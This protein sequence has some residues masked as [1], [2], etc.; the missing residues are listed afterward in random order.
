MIENNSVHLYNVIHKI[1]KNMMKKAFIASILFAI[2]TPFHAHNMNSCVD[3]LTFC[4]MYCEMNDGRYGTIGI[5][6]TDNVKEIDGRNYTEV[7]VGSL[8][9]DGSIR[10]YMREAKDQIMY[11]METLLKEGIFKYYREEEGKVYAYS[12]EK[13]EEELV[14]DFSLNVGDAFVRANGE[15]MKVMEVTDTMLFVYTQWERCK[16]LVL[17]SEDVSTEKDIW[18]EG[19]GSLNTGILSCDVLKDVRVAKLIG[20][21]ASTDGMYGLI[22]DIKLCPFAEDNFKTSWLTFLESDESQFPKVNYEFADDTLHLYGYM[23]Q[24]CV[25]SVPLQCMVKGNMIEIYEI[26]FP[27]TLGTTCTSIYKVDA[28]FSG[29]KNGVYQVSYNGGESVEVECGDGNTADASRVQD[30]DRQTNSICL[31][32]L[33]GRPVSTPIRGICVRNGKKIQMNQ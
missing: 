4:H 6:G 9:E 16:K 31:Y 13:K 32:D 10:L 21:S 26:H 11:S 12:E 23:E 15:K 3:G 8:K 7:N 20:R 5:V 28:K 1:Q 18:V 27:G 22:Y 14:L 33:T 17:Q 29:F 19:I 2:C 30:A 24:E 25:G